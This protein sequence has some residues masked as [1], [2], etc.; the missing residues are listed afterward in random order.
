MVFVGTMNER[1]ETKRGFVISEPLD[2]LVPSGVYTRVSSYK[3]WIDRAIRKY[4]NDAMVSDGDYS[5]LGSKPALMSPA[6][7]D[8][9]VNLGVRLSFH[10]MRYS[11]AGIVCCS[12]VWK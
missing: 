2:I 7:V 1:Q 3:D 6:P 9:D 12:D 4:A 10:E 8:Q 5:V 11:I